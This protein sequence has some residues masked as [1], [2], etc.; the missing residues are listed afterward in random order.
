VGKTSHKEFLLK[1][2]IFLILLLPSYGFASNL[3]ID[4]NK[5]FLGVKW[6]SSHEEVEAVLGKPNGYYRI[7]KNRTL[8]FY[9]KSVSLLIS[10]NRFREVH[11][12]GDLSDALSELPT[13]FN[14]KYDVSN[15]TINGKP[16]LRERFEK[17]EEALK[18]ELGVPSYSVSA[19]TDEVFVD[20]S[21]SGVGG[22]GSENEFVLR[23]ISFAYQL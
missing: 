4:I 18:I 7:N 5:G 13:T 22:Y 10:R 20:L 17:V 16:F 23:K 8:L 6:L 14:T 9:G 19:G 15:L 3:D 11:I 12:G 2:L 21:F 1:N